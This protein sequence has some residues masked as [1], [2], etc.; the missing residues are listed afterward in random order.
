L[1]IEGPTFVCTFGVGEKHEGYD[2]HRTGI[3]LYLKVSNVGSAPASM[4][5]VA[6]GYRWHIIPFSRQWWRYGIF[7]FWLSEQTIALDDFQATIGDQLKLFPFLFQ[8]SS[9]SGDSSDT[10]LEVGRSTNGVVY[11]EQPDS[12]GGCF[13]RARNQIVKLKI[14]ITDSFGGVHSQVL[15]IPRVTLAE[16]R[17][18]NPSFGRTISAMR[19]TAEP[20]EFPIDSH[21]NLLPPDI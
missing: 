15:K 7:R 1:N 20:I 13:P 17:R 16:A 3:A 9:I 8:R 19:R 6:V 12:F 5:N 18:Y 11:F 21:G 10:Y 14:K 2:V 4:E